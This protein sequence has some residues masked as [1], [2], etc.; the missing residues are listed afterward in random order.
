MSDTT[1]VET[2][3]LN[4]GEWTPALV[5]VWMFVWKMWPGVLDLLKSYLQARTSAAPHTFV[6][7][8]V[9]IV[10]DPGVREIVREVAALASSIVARPA[11]AD[12]S[13]PRATMAASPSSTG[14]GVA[15]GGGAAR[16]SETGTGSK[17]G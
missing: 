11:T 13:P 3:L 4:M 10:L 12:V 15:S 1:F 7:A 9:T 2:I 8:T 17:S 6:P 14:A 16:S 5:I